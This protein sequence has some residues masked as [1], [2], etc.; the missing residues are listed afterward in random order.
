MSTAC[1]SVQSV[2]SCTKG[3]SCFERELFDCYASIE[4]FQYFLEGRDF[5]LKTDHKLIVKKFQHN[6]PAASPRQARYIDYILQF[7]SNIKHVSGKVN[8]A[9]TLSRPFEPPLINLLTPVNKP[10]DFLELA[11]AQ[12]S[13][14]KCEELQYV[15]ITPALSS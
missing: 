11:I 10:I 13:N 8:I 5:T 15:T 1:I 6:F 4:H 3:W 9:D 12:R 2:N 7:T 14:S